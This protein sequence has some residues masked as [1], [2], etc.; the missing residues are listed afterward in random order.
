MWE[1]ITLYV[2]AVNTPEGVKTTVGRV[3]DGLLILRS[4]IDL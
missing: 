1:G 2:C 3:G 4:L